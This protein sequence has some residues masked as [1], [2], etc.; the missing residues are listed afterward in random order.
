[1]HDPRIDELARQLVRYSTGLKRGEK[2]LIDLY[3]VPEE[4]GIALVRE[5]R[6]RGAVPLVTVNSM[7]VSRE[8]LMGA[9]DEQF[10]LFSKHRMA[11]MRDMDAYI[12]VR[13]CHNIAEWSDVPA[14]K[15]DLAQGYTR[16]VLRHRVEKTRWC[17]LRWPHPGM[18]QQAGMSTEA[19]EDF[20]FRVCLLDYK[21]MKPA[22]NALAKLMTRT[23]KVKIVGTGTDL[24]FSIKGI[25]AIPCGGEYNIPDG[26]CFTAP[27]RNSVNGVISHNAGTIYN[28]IPFDGIV[29]EFEKGK[30]VKAE[31]D[32]KNKEINKILDAD[33]G[34]RYVGEFALGFNPEIREP[35]RD[36]LFDEKIAGSFHFTPG[37]AYDEAS[38]GN[39][40]KVHWDMVSI[41][42]SDYGGG[43]IWFDGKLIRKNG[44][45]LPK[46]LDTL[47]W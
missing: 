3:D 5:A 22:M 16:K 17:V 26:E 9:T 18:A 2:V 12:A 11:E 44:K 14:S 13:G 42:R 33:E 19:F 7:R 47:N 29:L 38:N 6:R 4:V 1:M 27:V 28:G 25:P 8:L 41:Q 15:I 30:I 43:E 35:M 34:A 32:G 21:A 40:S 37:Q 23:D 36:I 10:R 46:A 45:F 39:K 20:Y 24:E 31:A